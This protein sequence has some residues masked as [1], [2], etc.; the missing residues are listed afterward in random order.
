MWFDSLNLETLA[1]KLARN[2]QTKWKSVE[3]FKFKTSRLENSLKIW[4]R[5]KN[6]V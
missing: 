1:G 4:W 3:K 2:P 5:K 6:V